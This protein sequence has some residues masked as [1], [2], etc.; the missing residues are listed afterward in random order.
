[1]RG[2]ADFQFV[3][4]GGVEM[5]LHKL[6]ITISAIPMFI[7]AH[8][9]AVAEA[10]TAT[11]AM[12]KKAL[13]PLNLQISNTARMC[14]ADAQISFMV[15]FTMLNSDLDHLGFLSDSDLQRSLVTESII[16][17][18][19]DFTQKIGKCLGRSVKTPEFDGA[20]DHLQTL[21]KDDS[22]TVEATTTAETG[23]G[24]L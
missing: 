11:V 6:I 4:N 3:P 24:C 12:A 2:P 13:A 7:L 16:K 5:R 19:N 23:R 17:K 20:V 9:A 22:Q 18:I 1:V 8:E 15:D 10:P 21:M 14:G